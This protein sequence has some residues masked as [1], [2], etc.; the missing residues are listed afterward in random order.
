M[1]ESKKEII[2]ILPEKDAATQI[3]RTLHATLECTYLRL[4][5]LRIK[6]KS[7]L[8]QNIHFG[9]FPDWRSAGG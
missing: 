3:Y 5:T 8:A 7:N 6:K 9:A 2:K 4:E 1:G